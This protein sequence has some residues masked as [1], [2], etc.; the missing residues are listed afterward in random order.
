MDPINIIVGLNIIATFGANISG[1]KKGFKAT[2]T[3]YKEKPATYLQDVPV[4]LSV[5]TLIAMILGVFQIGTLVYKI[6]YFDL[7]LAGLILYLIFSWIQVWAYRSLGENYS[8]QIIIFRNH[9]LVTK[10]PYK[11]V[12]HPQYISQ[13]IIDLCAGLALL[14]WLLTPL[15]LI[16]LPLLILRASFEDRLLQKHFKESFNEYKKKSGFIIPFIG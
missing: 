15:A 14:S 13:F 3:S 6:E 1:A 2:I 5:V 8:Q 16:E 4:W 10:G 7:R 9:S 11:F 12:R